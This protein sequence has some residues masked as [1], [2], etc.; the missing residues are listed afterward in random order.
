MVTSYPF[1]NFSSEIVAN[2]S[3]SCS[4][5]F[6]LFIVSASNVTLV[7]VC[8]FSFS[9][10][11]HVSIVITRPIWSAPNLPTPI[12]PSFFSVAIC[13]IDSSNSDKGTPSPSSEILMVSI[14]WYRTESSSHSDA[15]NSI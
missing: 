15:L 9:S 3:N 8:L 6:T 10:K 2:T 1:F 13:I 7:T 5:K 11:A 12:P 4:S 14:L